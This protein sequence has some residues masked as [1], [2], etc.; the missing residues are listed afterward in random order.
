MDDAPLAS[1]PDGAAALASGNTEIATLAL[2]RHHNSTGEHTAERAAA[3]HIPSARGTTQKPTAGGIETAARRHDTSDGEEHNYRHTARGSAVWD[4]GQTRERESSPVAGM[5]RAVHQHGRRR[6][7]GHRAVHLACRWV[8]RQLSNN[9]G[10]PRRM[11]RG[12]LRTAHSHSNA[13]ASSLAPSQRPCDA[14]RPQMT[15]AAHPRA[16]RNACM[17]VPCRSATLR[18]AN[19][20]P[21]RRHHG[22]GEPCLSAQIEIAV[23]C[24]LG[25]C[26]VDPAC[27]SRRP[28]PV[29]AASVPSRFTFQVRERRRPWAAET[30][31]GSGG[32]CGTWVGLR[33]GVQSPAASPTHCVRLGRALRV[34]RV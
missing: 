14:A 33:D 29:Y 19:A 23:V 4:V 9:N 20:S 18:H 10:R 7:S 3:R 13:G 12:Q 17:P 8:R 11:Q 2:R 34:P 16:R 15:A 22:G 32:G 21:A 1:G 5:S 27:V 31:C 28:P 24:T 25:S 6:R 30:G 26:A